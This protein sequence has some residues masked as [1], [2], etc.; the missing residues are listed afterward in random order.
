MPQVAERFLVG[1]EALALDQDSWAKVLSCAVDM[2]GAL[3][4]HVVRYNQRAGHQTAFL[5]SGC[6]FLQLL[7]LLR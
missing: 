6:H 1:P 5:A 7:N 4:Q 2:H 3:K